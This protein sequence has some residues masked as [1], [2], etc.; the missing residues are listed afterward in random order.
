MLLTSEILG[1]QIMIKK[2][3]TNIA[4]RPFCIDKASIFHV[5]CGLLQVKRMLAL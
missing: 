5:Y 2:V 1:F 3:W 4:F